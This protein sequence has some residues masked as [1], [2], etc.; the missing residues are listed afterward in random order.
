MGVVMF[1]SWHNFFLGRPRAFFPPQGVMSTPTDPALYELVKARVYAR[2]PTHSAYR[3]GHVVREYKRAFAE[4]HGARKAAYA[5]SS[6]GGLVRWFAER[7][8]NESGGIGYDRKNT[9]YRP[10]VRVTS[11][12]PKTW[13]ELAPRDVK[14]AKAEKK[15]KGRVFRFKRPV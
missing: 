15:A 3:S 12:T 4:K 7:W 14:A 10:T 5:G 13:G 2:I 6:D 1:L 9:L 11:E 8:R